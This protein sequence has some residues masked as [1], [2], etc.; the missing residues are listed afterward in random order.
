M[1]LILVYHTWTV[2]VVK[3]YKDDFYQLENQ[4]V[5]VTGKEKT[6]FFFY[7]DKDDIKR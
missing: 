7:L 3:V 1:I 2:S 5:M 6:F 4:G